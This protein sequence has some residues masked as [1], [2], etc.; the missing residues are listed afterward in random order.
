MESKQNSVVVHSGN[1][2]GLVL[3]FVGSAAG[4]MTAFCTH[5]KTLT[6][7]PPTVMS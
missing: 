3:R 2:Q 5:S 1:K 4:E 7:K 6:E